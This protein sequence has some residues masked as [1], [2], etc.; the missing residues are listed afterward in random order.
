M[1]QDLE[2]DAHLVSFFDVTSLAFTIGATGASLLV[3]AIK[4]LA[5]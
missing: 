4:H 3:S 1:E 2:M 5:L